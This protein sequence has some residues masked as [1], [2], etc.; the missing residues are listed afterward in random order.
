MTAQAAAPSPASTTN[1]SEWTAARATVE[2]FDGYLNDLRK[3]GFTLITGLLAVTGYLSSS[4]ATALSPSVKL[5]V[6]TAILVLVVTLSILDGLYRSFQR[7]AIT[8]A[9]ILEGFLN[10]DLTS[11]IVHYVD[12]G[13]FRSHFLWVYVAFA[14]STFVLGASV[15][16]EYSLQLIVMAVAYAIALGFIITLGSDWPVGMVD[17][18]VDRKLVTAG[19]PV[20]V[21]FT[22]LI[23]DAR[24]AQFRVDCEVFD[25]SGE[26]VQALGSVEYLFP[27]MGTRDWLWQK[28]D[29]A[30]GLYEIRGPWSLLGVEV[31]RPPKAAS[32]VSNY[33]PHFELGRRRV[34]GDYKPKIRHF[35]KPLRGSHSLI[36]QVNKRPDT[37]APPGGANQPDE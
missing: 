29:V 36:I 18:S 12:A 26:L 13:R 20:R 11:A 28:T 21:T 24:R 22:N 32:A 6:G 27:Y 10:L 8:R 35:E 7:G 14:T 25:N 3:Y 31:K 19:E 17:W 4:P 30:P 16:W 37:V 23:P 33:F 15:L 34:V 5:G 2:R 9:R 1:M